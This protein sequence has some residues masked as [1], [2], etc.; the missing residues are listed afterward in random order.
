MC[1]A[2]KHCVSSP[3]L[4]M[5]AMNIDYVPRK[6]RHSSSDLGASQGLAMLGLG[7]MLILLDSRGSD[8][9]TPLDEQDSGL[10]DAAGDTRANPDTNSTDTNPEDAG[11]TDVAPRSDANV[12]DA[13]PLPNTPVITLVRGDSGPYH[14]LRRIAID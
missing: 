13:A 4:T 11:T 10:V 7:A 2:G 9:P 1:G 8:T 5:G 14:R 6:R 3:R 12:A